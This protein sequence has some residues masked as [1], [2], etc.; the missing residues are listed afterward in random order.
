MPK[1][2]PS[3]CE[4]CSTFLDPSSRH[5]HLCPRCWFALDI[6]TFRGFSLQAGQYALPFN[7]NRTAR[8]FAP[9]KRPRKR[10]GEQLELF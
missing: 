4:R 1:R 8:T 5:K 3:V 9:R 7:P 10:P 6:I 2:R